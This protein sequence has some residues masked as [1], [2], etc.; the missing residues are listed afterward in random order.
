[1]DRGLQAIVYVDSVVLLLTSA[2]NTSLS[3]NML[4][5]NFILPGCGGGLVAIMSD[6]SPYGG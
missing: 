2:I 5:E 3:S 6:L 4:R 1:M